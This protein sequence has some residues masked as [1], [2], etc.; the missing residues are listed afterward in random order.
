VRVAVRKLDGVESVDV[1]LERASAD[2]RLRPANR[3]TL[4][5]LRQIIKNNGFNAK[6]ASITVVGTLSERNGEIVLAVSGTDSTLLIDRSKSRSTAFA[7]ALQRVKA[8]DSSTV[9]A[10]G[11]V[12]APARPS[13]T[14]QL[15]LE[16]LA[17]A[18]K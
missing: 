13:H 18:A 1:S 9:E 4:A 10:V 8:Q 7:D 3:V 2:I 14:D 16:T 11:T 15:I 17:P 6:D 12:A 5:Q